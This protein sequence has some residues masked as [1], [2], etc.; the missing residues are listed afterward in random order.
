[1]IIHLHPHPPDGSPAQ[2][3]NAAHW[4]SLPNQISTL[5]PGTCS[6]ATQQLG[7]EEKKTENKLS[8]S[9][10]VN[11]KEEKIPSQPLREEKKNRFVAL[12]LI[13]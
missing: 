8:S 3:P 9:R 7:P 10:S 1:M 12:N 6:P 5:L 11:G 2:K 13:P 4:A